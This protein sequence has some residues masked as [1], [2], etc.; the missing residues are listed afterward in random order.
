MLLHSSKRYAI[1]DS[2]G[3]YVKKCPECGADI[4]FD[5]TTVCPKCGHM[6]TEST[7]I[8]SFPTPD[9]V[10]K[11]TLK[12]GKPGGEDKIESMMNELD[13]E[14]N[15]HEE[16]SEDFS[17]VK[18]DSGKDS[19]E[20]TSEEEASK[21]E[22]PK[23]SE[24]RK[25]VSK[26][27]QESFHLYDEE[28]PEARRNYIEDKKKYEEFVKIKEEEKKQAEGHGI[29]EK[30]RYV[31]SGKYSFPCFVACMVIPPLA[32]I[33]AVLSVG[34]WKRF[35]ACLYGAVTGLF[36]YF[37]IGLFFYVSPHMLKAF[38]DFLSLFLPDRVITTLRKTYAGIPYGKLKG[39]IH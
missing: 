28:I 31:D 24:N 36:V 33:L 6:F 35:K 20:E 39:M 12:A 27:I 15:S 37:A 23:D 22:E 9:T 14:N 5:D 34:K 29:N 18:E 21:T 3:D 10:A 38:D 11:T 19:G 1:L 32:I 4:F 2:G 25:P 8:G 7:D 13:E 16:S 30:V 17:E 26:L